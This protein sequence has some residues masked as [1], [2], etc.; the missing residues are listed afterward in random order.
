VVQVYLHQDNT[1]GEIMRQVDRLSLAAAWF[2]GVAAALVVC[3]APVCAHDASAGAAHAGSHAGTAA[4]T[5]AVSAVSRNRWG[6]DYFP[7]LPLVNQDGVTLRFYDDLMKD[8]NVAINVIYT[9]C[10]DEC[11]LETATLVRVQ[12]ILGE[13][14]GK[15]IHFYS[16][17]IDPE[18]DTPKVLKAYAEKF[19]V[20]PGWQFL[21]GKPEDV[22]VIVRK[23]GL[24]RG[25]DAQN[26][27]GH[28]AS[29]MVG[30]VPGGL[31]LRNSAVDNPNFL[32]AKIGTFLGKW[33]DIMPQK[34]Y[35]EA[36]FVD[37]KD[38][39]YLF[40]S[41]CSA[42]HTIG[43]GRR[44]GPDLLGVTARRDRNWV[45][46]Y[47]QSPNSMQAQGDATAAELARQYTDVRMP[48]LNLSQEDVIAVIKYIESAGGAAKK[49][50]GSTAGTIQ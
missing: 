24:S 39:Q 10:K 29:L 47:I 50:I 38:G 3:A 6:A 23:L 5:P 40:Q 31:W 28:T 4:A 41:R 22:K 14:V 9:S 17:S 42:C 19:G 1:T 46:R 7:N 2:F 20:G 16:I 36:R 18:T 44:H 33:N 30:N 45:A 43:E 27:D 49:V 15:D 11:P 13:R 35:T 32:V 21:T 26:R 12:K 37:L 34:S 25:S 8:K 48:N